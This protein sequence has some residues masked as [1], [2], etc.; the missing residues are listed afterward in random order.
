MGWLL[1]EAPYNCTDE[2][3]L[4]TNQHHL[5]I[6]QGYLC[7]RKTVKS[8]APPSPAHTQNSHAKHTSTRHTCKTHIHKAHKAHK[9]H[10]LTE[11]SW[12]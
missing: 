11:C 6:D 10:I 8:S 5:E 2:H 3:V 4:G 7:C 1:I 9:A 12:D